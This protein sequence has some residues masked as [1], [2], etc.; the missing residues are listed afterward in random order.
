MSK[1][2]Y[3]R[4]TY[5]HAYRMYEE[6]T[7]LYACAYTIDNETLYPRLKQVPV[8]GVFVNARRGTDPL[9]RYGQTLYFAELKAD[10]TPRATGRVE[11][12]SRWYATTYEEGVELYNERVQSRKERILDL[13]CQTERDFLPGPVDLEHQLDGIHTE[14]ALYAFIRQTDAFQDVKHPL[15]DSVVTKLYELRQQSERED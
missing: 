14:D 10:G 15:W 2:K 11:Y 5:D 9:F 4:L 13:L 7:I 6:G 3:R 1:M 12:T 8:Q